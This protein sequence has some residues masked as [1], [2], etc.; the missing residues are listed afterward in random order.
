[1]EGFNDIWANILNDKIL[2][3]LTNPD[4]DKIQLEEKKENKTLE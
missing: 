1:M 3:E 2:T 4:K